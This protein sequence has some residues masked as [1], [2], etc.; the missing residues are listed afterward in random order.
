MNHLT[1]N[2][3]ILLAILSVNMFLS[4]YVF[5]N[6]SDTATSKRDWFNAC[7]AAT[8]AALFGSVILAV[9]YLI[10]FAIALSG[11]IDRKLHLSFTFK[12]LI[13]KRNPGIGYVKAI[14]ILKKNLDHH[15]SIVKWWMFSK[16]IYI[17]LVSRVLAIWEIEKDK[18][19]V[20]NPDLLS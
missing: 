19:P 2:T 18:P 14:E 20:D 3:L 4:G 6:Q 15:K 17:L 9:M 7:F 5:S 10:G 8:I 16:R 11:F 12:Y 1:V 13:M